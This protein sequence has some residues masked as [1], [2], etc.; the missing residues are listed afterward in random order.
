MGFMYLWIVTVEIKS[1]KVSGQ[2]IESPS[3]LI[4]APPTHLP[5]FTLFLI[6]TGKDEKQLT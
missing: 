2:F 1:Y 6:W 3:K 4:T 5:Y